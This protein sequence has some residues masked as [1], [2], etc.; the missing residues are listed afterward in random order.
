MLSKE[1]RQMRV[2]EIP[3]YLIQI[4]SLQLTLAGILELSC[5]PEVVIKHADKIMSG[6]TVEKPL[7]YF[8]VIAHRYCKDRGIRPN[9]QYRDQMKRNF[10]IEESA[11]KIHFEQNTSTGRKKDFHPTEETDSHF[12]GRDGSDRSYWEILPDERRSRYGSSDGSKARRID[13]DRDLDSKGEYLKFEDAKKNS[14]YLRDSIRKLHKP[15]TFNPFAQEE[16]MQVVE[17]FEGNR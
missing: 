13:P 3:S 14:L 7:H 8:I 5:F 9:Y 15:P 12:E 16:D 1:A 2:E 6:K 11:P 4:K 10:N 17:L